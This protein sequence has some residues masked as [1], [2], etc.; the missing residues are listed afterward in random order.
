MRKLSLL[1]GTTLGIAVGAALFSVRPAWADLP[2]VDIV[3]DQL[4]QTLN[5]LVT[6]AINQVQVAITGVH[7]AAVPDDG[8][9]DRRVPAHGDLRRPAA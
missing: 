4:M 8:R 9:G 1:A 3:T 6:D 5:K 7:D 2:V